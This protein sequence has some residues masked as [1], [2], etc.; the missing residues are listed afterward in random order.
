MAFLMLLFPHEDAE[1]QIMSF[2]PTITE[3]FGTAEIVST[4]E[5]NKNTYT[6]NGR[7]TSKFDLSEK[8]TI[9]IGGFVYHP[10][11]AI[12]NLSVGFGIQE[13]YFKSVHLE[14]WDFGT[15][16][17]YDAKILILP[18][19]NYNLELFSRRRNPFIQQ[20]LSPGLSPVSYEHGINL[21]Y[22]TRPLKLNLGYA[23]ESL[24]FSG[25]RT[26]TH[27]IRFG[28]G[29]VYRFFKT[30]LNY[31]HIDLDSSYDLS[32]AS[33]ILYLN[34][35]FEYKRI[36]LRSDIS[37]QEYDQETS[38]RSFTDTLFDW[39]ERLLVDIYEDLEASGIYNFR[40]MERL[41]GVDVYGETVKYGAGLI[42]RYYDSITTKFSY[43]ESESDATSSSS[44]VDEYSLH[45]DYEKRIR[46]GILKASYSDRS[47][48]IMREGSQRIIN[49][50]HEASAIPPDN[51]FFLDE[52]GVDDSS[53]NLT[54]EEPETGRIYEVFRDLHY[55]T[56]VIGN[57][58]Y[59]TIL[60]V[61]G[62]SPIIGGTDLFTFRAN[63]MLP[64]ESTTYETNR[65]TY[66]VRLELF[67]KRLIPYYSLSTLKQI[68]IEGEI[69]GGAED[70]RIQV[71]GL[72]VRRKAVSL[73]AEYQDVESRF[74]PLTR[75]RIRADYH[76]KYSDRTTLSIKA[77]YQQT[78]YQENEDNIVSRNVYEEDLFTLNSRANFIFPRRNITMYVGQSFSYRK[79]QN[80][81]YS[82]GASSGLNWKLGLL[83]LN[84]GLT[85]RYLVSQLPL[86]DIVNQNVFFF[87]RAIRELF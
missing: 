42:H 7:D 15:I 84:T 1:S 3:W 40:R 79:A 16:E 25:N 69:P 14:G 5:L 39:K 26:D 47:S 30:R 55:I 85:Y 54:I 45:I 66:M 10:G 22:K 4:Y 80:T 52:T 11:L 19:H 62:I 18:Y 34:N 28:A 31:S 46:Y 76:D 43:S 78:D 57:R 51:R 63:Y 20:S 44:R 72:N 64:E 77:L 65:N 75:W 6:G 50:V 68:E 23:F 53:I 17:E 8:V 49:E 67:K 29:H 41:D 35:R 74:S 33:D 87:F 37:I 27:T 83:D 82:V 2:T 58:T 61:D 71:I 36:D 56:E 9:G 86:D 81:T 59:I 21:F 32:T 73:G 13:S 48:E 24:R 60:S 38:E 12:Y 70:S